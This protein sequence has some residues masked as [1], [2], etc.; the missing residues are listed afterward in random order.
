[1]EDVVLVTGIHRTKSWINAA[2]PGGQ[3]AARA[4]FEVEVD[5]NGDSVTINRQLSASAIER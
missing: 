3:A 2:F 4:S 1:M 5:A